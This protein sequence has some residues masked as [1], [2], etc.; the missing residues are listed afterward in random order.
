MLLDGGFGVMRT[1][2]VETAI[3]PQHRAE[4]ELVEA[5]DEDE[6]VFHGVML[7]EM[8]QVKANS[9][10]RRLTCVVALAGIAKQICRNACA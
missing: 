3:A 5:D 6:E 10:A 8:I 9:K 4:H 1:S 2:G 7:T